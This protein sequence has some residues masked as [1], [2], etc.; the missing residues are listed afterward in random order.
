MISYVIPRDT[1][2]IFRHDD[3][4]PVTVWVGRFTFIAEFDEIE[5]AQAICAELNRS[6]A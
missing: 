1:G 2:I 4:V 3:A 6:L 5:T